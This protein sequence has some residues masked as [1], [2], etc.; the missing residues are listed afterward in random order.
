MGYAAKSYADNNYVSQVQFQSAQVFRTVKDI[1]RDIK[2]M[3]DKIFEIDQEMQFAEA[4]L[5]PKWQ[6]RK[7]Y[8]GR[9][10][11]ELIRELRSV[12]KR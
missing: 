2:R 5:I 6:I 7:A 4:G 11:D 12:E 8:Y 10:K 3:D 9:Q 1:K